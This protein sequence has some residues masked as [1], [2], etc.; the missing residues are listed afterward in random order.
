MY[1]SAPAG[2][3][4]AALALGVLAHCILAI[5]NERLTAGTA[6]AE[7]VAAAGAAAAA[8]SAAAAAAAAVAGDGG[9][10]VG[11]EPLRALANFRSYG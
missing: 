9:L 7:V 6:V 5:R 3:L 2:A 11:F 10:T 8:G 4:T 1:A